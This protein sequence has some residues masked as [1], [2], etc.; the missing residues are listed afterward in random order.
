MQYWFRLSLVVLL[1]Y[2]PLSA[3]GQSIM[4]FGDLRAGAAG[5]GAG[6]G[7]S[8]GMGQKNALNKS[9]EKVTRNMS[10][11]QKEAFAAQSQAVNKY[12]SSGCQ[13]ELAKQL[14]NAEKSF[15]YVL[16][17]ITLRDGAKSSSR[18]PVLQKLV[19]ATKKQK[20]LDQAIK[21]QKSIVEFHKSAKRP[22]E[23]VIV[24]TNDD[25]S[26]LYLDKHDYAGAETVL[27]DSL[28]IYSKYPA[29]PTKQKTD[30]L[31]SYSN[32]LRKLKK[33]VEA[34]KVDKSLSAPPAAMQQMPAKPEVQMPI[35]VNPASQPSP[36]STSTTV[37]ADNPSPSIMPAEET[38]AV[39]SPSTVAVPVTTDA[40]AQAAPATNEIPQDANQATKPVAEPLPP[41]ATTPPTDPEVD[42]AP[43][44]K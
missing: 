2:L 21:Y 11:A 10:T 33:N 6:A 28:A 29:L 23:R 38:G 27:K 42:K 15:A 4:E 41:P 25:L 43:M 9:F 24:K 36:E 26:A 44:E 39:S 31:K 5:T 8:A 12:W 14:S 3:F 37:P 40:A 7:L 13:Y 16:Q 35:P 19:M 30:T 22:D 32:V 1:S 18:V 17:V 20:K 34:D